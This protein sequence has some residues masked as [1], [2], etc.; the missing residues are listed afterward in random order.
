[1]AAVLKSFLFYLVLALHKMLY[2]LFMNMAQMLE[3]ILLITSSW[4]HRAQ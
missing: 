4:N 3:L 2:S 1:M